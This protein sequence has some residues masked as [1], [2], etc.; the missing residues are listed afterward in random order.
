M[1]RHIKLVC[2]AVVWV[3]FFLLGDARGQIQE[4]RDQLKVRFGPAMSVGGQ[5]VFKKGD[6]DITVFYD[7]RGRSSLMI[8]A[9]VDKKSLNSQEVAIL[10]K[11][12]LNEWRGPGEWAVIKNT[13]EETTYFRTD[14]KVFAR[15]NLKQGIIYFLAPHAVRDLQG[16]K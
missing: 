8:Y 12:T 1:Q 16:A 15:M 2:L 7:D 14:K 6:F 5:D 13:P 9:I 11:K 4:T 3:A 10:L